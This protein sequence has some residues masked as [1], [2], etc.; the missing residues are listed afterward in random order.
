M[1]IAK[2]KSERKRELGWSRYKTYYSE[3]A[4]LLEVKIETIKARQQHKEGKKSDPY[5]T[6]YLLRKDVEGKT[7]NR[8]EVQKTAGSTRKKDRVWLQKEDRDWVREAKGEAGETERQE[9]KQ[10]EKRIWG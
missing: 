9:D 5:S 4:E 8:N 7:N 1:L 6:F 10:K 3:N 2:K